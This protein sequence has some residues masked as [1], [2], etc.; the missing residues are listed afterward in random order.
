MNTSTIEF[1]S[2]DKIL[3]LTTWTEIITSQPLLQNTFILRRS[4]A[5]NYPDIIKLATILIKN[6]RDIINQ[7]ENFLRFS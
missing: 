2:H 1:Q 6:E 5:V 3:F 7:N 4:G